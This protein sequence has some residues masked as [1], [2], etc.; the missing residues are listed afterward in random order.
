MALIQFEQ[1]SRRYVLGETEVTAVHGVDFAVPAGQFVALWG[2]S[3]SGKSTLCNLAGTLDTPSEGR[4]LFEGSDV[5]ALSDDARSDHRRR[6]LGFIFQQFNL[7]EVLSA[8]E[9]VM[10]PL[11]I[12]GTPPGECRERAREALAGVGLEAWIDHRP[13]QLSG[14][15][16][17]RVAVARALVTR[18]RLV[19]ADEPTANLDS[20]TAYRIVELMRSFNHVQGT[21]FLFA[22][23]DQR[24]LDQV[25]RRVHLRDGRI[26]TDEDATA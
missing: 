17:Q 26:E 15:Q 5:A 20:K 14:G 11:Q 22:T 12:R 13:A 21:T 4:V 1:L 7:V 9:N 6:N 24:L 23:H 25:D 8:L 3:G 16:Q 18:P 19:I 10:L 2:P